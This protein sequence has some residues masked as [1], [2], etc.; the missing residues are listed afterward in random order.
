M[1]DAVDAAVEQVVE[2][3]QQVPE[4][5]GTHQRHVEHTV[6]GHGVGQLLHAADVVLTDADGDAEQQVVVNQPVVD[7]HLHARRLVAEEVLDQTPRGAP[8]AFAALFL[9]VRKLAHHPRVE[10]RARYVGHIAAL[11]VVRLLV[12]HHAHVL[13]ERVALADGLHGILIA[14]R[15]T[16][17]ADPVVARSH[18]DHRQQHLV[19]TDLLLDE[20][21]V[22]HLV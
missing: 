17:R 11:A 8:A 9:E 19:G 10:T 4:M 1:P 14:V 5:H 2:A 18:G 13:Q 22:H 3:E 12:R 15:N 16:E 7:P 20:K 6:V 21:S